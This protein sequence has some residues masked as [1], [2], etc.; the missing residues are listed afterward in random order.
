MDKIVIVSKSMAYIVFHDKSP[1]SLY[2]DTDVRELIYWLLDIH[3]RLDNDDI[4]QVIEIDEA[5]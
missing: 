4:T 3:V 5:A 1:I 2:S